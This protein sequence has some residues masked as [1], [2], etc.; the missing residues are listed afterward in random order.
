MKVGIIKGAGTGAELAQAFKYAIESICQNMGKEVEIVE[1]PHI[2]GTYGQSRQDATEAIEATVAIDVDK[3][4]DFYR[5]FCRSGGRVAFRTAINAEAL[6][7]FRQHAKAVKTVLIPVG[8]RRL[9]FV[10]D[11]MQGYYSNDRW[12]TGTNILHFSGHV[13]KEDFS[14][15]ID[16]SLQSAKVILREPFQVWV[17]YKHHLFANVLEKW[18]RSSCGYAKLYQPNHATDELFQYLNLEDDGGDL[19]FVAGNEVGDILHEILIFYL[20]MGTRT[21]LCSKNV[22]LHVDYAGLTEYQTVHGSADEIGSEGI[23]NPFATLRCVGEMLEDFLSCEG[24]AHAM[25]VAIGNAIRNEVVTAD[26]GGKSTTS[27]V[28]DHVLKMLLS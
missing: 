15:V 12:H 16:F 20:G 23:V 18:T 7:L 14:R 21:S 24:L 22:Y 2:F 9:L 6:Y 1:C 19:L 28:V 8:K 25:G 5:D 13:S 11:E 4:S 10:R 27:D 17:V 26:M 3:L